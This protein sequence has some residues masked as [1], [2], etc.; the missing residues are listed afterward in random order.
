MIKTYDSHPE[1]KA[2]EKFA[3][4]VTSEEFRSMNSNKPKWVKSLRL[5]RIAYS[6][7]GK[8]VPQFRPMFFTK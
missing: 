4:N 2:G 5:G 3:M 1:T 6:S 8:T 7:T